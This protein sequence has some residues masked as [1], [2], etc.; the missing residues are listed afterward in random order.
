ME[1][2]KRQTTS[3]NLQKKK[4]EKGQEKVNSSA[5]TKSKKKKQQSE[6][7]L[8][9]IDLT[10]RALDLQIRQAEEARL[11][12]SC[13]EKNKKNQEEDVQRM[14]KTR[15]SANQKKTRNKRHKRRPNQPRQNQTKTENVL[16]KIETGET[17]LS[18]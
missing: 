7:E 9:E 8:D 13:L 4:M 1:K 5:E 17:K 10:I 16:P 12:A 3:P 6:N 18:T 14:K 2:Q 11:G 15:T